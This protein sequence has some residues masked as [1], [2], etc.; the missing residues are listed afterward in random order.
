M[1]LV[2]SQA[3]VV[4]NQYDTTMVEHTNGTA[5]IGYTNGY[6]DDTIF[7]TENCNES[8]GEEIVTKEL[9]SIQYDYDGNDTTITT[10]ITYYCTKHIWVKNNNNYNNIIFNDS[11][12]CND[13][14]KRIG[15]YQLRALRSEG[16]YKD[17]VYNAEEGMF[18]E[19]IPIKDTDMINDFA[20]DL[21]KNGE[22]DNNILLFGII[23]MMTIRRDETTTLI[24]TTQN[25]ENKKI[26]GKISLEKKYQLRALRSEGQYENEVYTADEGMFQGPIPVMCLCFLLIVTMCLCFLL[27]VTLRLLGQSM[28]SVKTHTWLVNL[29]TFGSTF[30]IYARLGARLR[31]RLESIQ[32][33][34][35]PR[36]PS[37]PAYRVTY[38]Y[39]LLYLSIHV[40]SYLRKHD[41]SIGMKEYRNERVKRGTHLPRRKASFLIA[42][43]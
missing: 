12:Y 14:M 22:N 40:L 18:Q 41:Y 26:D 34:G 13:K 27:I 30:G 36:E 7:P 39:V 24:S 6:N 37:N 15:E 38:L 32:S 23:I 1:Q 16:Q 35:H 42:N 4:M 8:I 21:R 28:G 17:E 33:L 29:H 43:L 20:N 25:G 3:K 31:A 9:D 5:I 19:P 10:S 11:D 2:L